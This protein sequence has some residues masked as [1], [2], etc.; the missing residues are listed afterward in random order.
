MKKLFLML[1][2]MLTVAV[3]A[4]TQERHRYSNVTIVFEGKED[5]F[6]AEST[7]YVNYENQPVIKVYP[8]NSNEIVLYDSVSAVEE[9]VDKAGNTYWLGIYRKRGTDLEIG[10]QLF[11]DT[12]YGIR[13]ISMDL[14][15][16]VQFY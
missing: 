6:S 5:T 13:F 16:T 7:V 9:G 1:A 11:K 12:S 2:L 4:Q 14:K 8:P 3:S 10:I 15:T